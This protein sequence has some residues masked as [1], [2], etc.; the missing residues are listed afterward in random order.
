M[1]RRITLIEDDRRFADV[2]T[3]YMGAKGYKVQVLTP[4]FEWEQVEEFAPDAV[5]LDWML[6]ETSGIDLLKELRAR[7]QLA[8]IPVI[9]VTARNEE[10]DKIE[11]LLSGADDYITKPFGFGELEARLISVMRR[12]SRVA[13]AYRDE[14]LEI[15]PLR[16]RIRV[17]GEPRYLSQYEWSALEL[18]LLTDGT[19]SREDLVRHVWGDM[20]PSSVRSIDNLI[21]KLRKQIEPEEEPIYIVTDRGQGYRFVRYN[22]VLSAL[23]EGR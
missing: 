13:P 9:L 14:Y 19:V 18:L 15:V 6:P 8:L 7:K 1:A 10:L 4:P 12:A 23:S 21:L 3:R 5:L 16:K 11:G 2:F 22:R 20:P 17:R